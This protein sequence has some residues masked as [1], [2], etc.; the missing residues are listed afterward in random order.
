M[1]LPNPNPAHLTGL[2]G[3]DLVAIRSHCQSGSKFQTTP[4]RSESY[5][6]LRSTPKTNFGFTHFFCTLIEKRVASRYRDLS[7]WG[8]AA[9]TFED[10]ACCWLRRLNCVVW[11]LYY[12]TCC[13][14]W[15]WFLYETSYLAFMDQTCILY[16]SHPIATQSSLF[17]MC[18]NTL[19]SYMTLHP[20]SLL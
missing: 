17:L 2:C 14:C 13:T 8:N 12:A 10:F 20:H 18:G 15:V 19:Q 1:I 11:S 16:M 7:L 4:Q 3:K 5:I 6:S 9:N